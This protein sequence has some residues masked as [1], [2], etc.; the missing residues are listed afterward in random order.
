MNKPL[1]R[2]YLDPGRC[3]DQITKKLL[4]IRH[5]IF[6][7][8]TRACSCSGSWPGSYLT[9]ASWNIHLWMSMSSF[10]YVA[11]L[12]TVYGQSQSLYSEIIN[13]YKSKNNLKKKWN[14]Q[15]RDSLNILNSAFDT[16]PF[17]SLTRLW[18]PQWPAPEG[19]PVPVLRSEDGRRTTWQTGAAAEQD[20]PPDTEW[21]G[22]PQGRW[23]GSSKYN[24]L[25]FTVVMF[26]HWNLLN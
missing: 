9:T 2:L 22:S 13:I 6:R 19:R 25:F 7:P 10:F 5:K 11:H 17:W 26:L 23:H 14:K 4:K 16:F 3:Q 8:S 1:S 15:I 12:K 18:Q 21:Q 20:L 24:T